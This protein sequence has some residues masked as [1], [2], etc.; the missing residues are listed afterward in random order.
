MGKNDKI[1]RKVYDFYSLYILRFLHSDFFLRITISSVIR[2]MM[3]SPI[4]LMA[5]R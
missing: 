4:A 5:G 1:L 3:C 2:L